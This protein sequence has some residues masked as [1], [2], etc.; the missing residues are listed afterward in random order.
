MS[1]AT[2]TIIATAAIPKS[3]DY[4][5]VG[6]GA[7]GLAFVDSFLQGLLLD[8]SQPKQETP[9]TIVLL[10][11]HSAPGGQWNDSYRFVQLHQPSAMYG[12]ESTLLEPTP[13]PSSI[14]SSTTTTEKHRATRQEILE[15]YATLVQKWESQFNSHSN[16]VS[17]QFI[18]SATFDFS[19]SK[20]REGGGGRVYQFQVSAD[21]EDNSTTTVQHSIQ[22]TKRLVDA[23]YLEP[24]LPVSTA[25]KFDFDATKIKCV[26]VNEIVAGDDHERINKSQYFV[27][28]GA[29]KT[30][31]DAIVYLL[32]NR[33]I[34]PANILWMVPHD[35][36]ITA[37]ENIGNCM[38]FLHDATQL[39]QQQNKDLQSNE[40]VQRTFQLW[41]QQGKMYRLFNDT[42]A[43]P[44]KFNDATLSKNELEII[45]SLPPQQVIRGQGRVTRIDSETGALVMQN[46]SSV[47]LPWTASNAFANT[48]YVHCSAGAFNYT[49][50][51]GLQP[52]PVFDAAKQIITLQ[53]VYGTPGF[54][55]VGS[56]LG[57]LESLSVAGVLDDA[58]KN[59]LC[60][61]PTPSPTPS[62]DNT[63]G[64]SGGDVGGLS[65]DHGFVQRL[66]NLRNWLQTPHLRQ[67]LVGHRLFNLGHYATAEDMEKL[68][69]DTWAVL[70]EGGLVEE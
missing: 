39:S 4:L 68:V 17:F 49:K 52:K 58:Q 5:V 21:K 64:P 25:P 35:P 8:E 10:D 42:T 23:R 57:K 20:P 59:D 24:D 43:L 19:S 70:K 14:T 2:A 48:T 44:T 54:C 29:G 28:I 41:E 56:I 51:I 65:K 16:S 3:C 38:E 47:T 18:G 37:R 1:T 50:Q 40:I 11:Q 63:L 27:V 31:M 62:S 7:T 69:E 12:V 66:C 60:R 26:P 30:G 53:D 46:G 6:A 45:R 36:W 67:W 32:T 61:V 15:Y 33:H 22:L 55:F 9:L 34:A 13:P